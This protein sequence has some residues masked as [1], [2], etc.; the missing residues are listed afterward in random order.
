MMIPNHLQINKS[1]DVKPYLFLNT[2]RTQLKRNVNLETLRKMTDRLYIF[3]TYLHIKTNSNG[4]I[5]LMISVV[6]VKPGYKSQ[7]VTMP[8]PPHNPMPVK[9]PMLMTI[10]VILTQPLH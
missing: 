9:L 4:T 6:Y 3:M 8:M 7:E 1:V 10:L 5:I 2:T